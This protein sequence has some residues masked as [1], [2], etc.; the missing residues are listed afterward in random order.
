M[1]CSSYVI[2]VRYNSD[3]IKVADDVSLGYGCINKWVFEMFF[4]LESF[5]L[6]A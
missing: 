4:Y 2:N 5:V 3:Y 6:K 1:F